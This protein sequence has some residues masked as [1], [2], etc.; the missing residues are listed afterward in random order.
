MITW[1]PFATYVTPS[2]TFSTTPAASCPSTVG[3]GSIHLP[4]TKWRSE[5]QT[6][7]HTVRTSTSPGRGSM[8]STS[9]IVSG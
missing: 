5:W 4:S 3:I 8:M 6:P 9:S 1:S 7:L 2:P